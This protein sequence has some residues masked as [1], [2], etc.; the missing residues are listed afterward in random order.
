M[1]WCDATV[2]YACVCDSLLFPAGAE[3]FRGSS[4]SWAPQ[5]H[6]GLCARGDH[7][8]L[9]RETQ[10]QPGFCTFHCG[11]G[12]LGWLVNR[13]REGAVASGERLGSSNEGSWRILFPILFYMLCLWRWL[14]SALAYLL[15]EV[16]RVTQRADC[17]CSVSV[18]NRVVP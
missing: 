13:E 11:A 9:Q 3:G 18:D 17:C 6:V 14:P 7:S 5:Q 1:I 15:L 12:S 4:S 2:M 16:Q 10:C 8:P